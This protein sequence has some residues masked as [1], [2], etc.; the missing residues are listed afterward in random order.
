MVVVNC[1]YCA[2]EM[3]VTNRRTKLCAACRRLRSL[4]SCV[5]YKSENR[6]AISD[7]NK[8]YKI[9]NK[10]DISKYNSAYF[11]A[12]KDDINSR[13]VGYTADYHMRYPMAKLFANHRTRIGKIMSGVSK[14]D[15][16]FELLGC[17][18]AFFEEWIT[19]QCEDNQTL[20]NYGIY[21][22]HIDHVIPCN[23][24]DVTKTKEAKRCFHWSNLQPMNSAQNLAKGDTTTKMEQWLHIMKIN[25]FIKLAD[26]DYKTQYTILKFNRYKYV[27]A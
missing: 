14:R 1:A 8:T 13:R 15:S 20:E 3:E 24:F 19:Y 26:P 7:Y 5:K 11:Q 16:S 25:N 21:T 17:S 10:E 2:I 27:N 18:N 9:E 12:N 6:T 22:W 23:L 4:S